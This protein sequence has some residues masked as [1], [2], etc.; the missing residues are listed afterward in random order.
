ME[1]LGRGVATSRC[2]LARDGSQQ[3]SLFSGMANLEQR[4]LPPNS[5]IRMTYIFSPLLSSVSVTFSSVSFGPFL[6]VQVHLMNME[7]FVKKIQ[8]LFA[9]ICKYISFFRTAW[10]LIM[11]S[12]DSSCY[13]CFGKEIKENKQTNDQFSD[14]Y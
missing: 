3:L 2:I 10:N 8:I 6:P 13:Y 14:T 1:E 5:S 11:L 4:I 9:C 7:K 12:S